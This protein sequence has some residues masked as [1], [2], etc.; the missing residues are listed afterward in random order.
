MNFSHQMLRVVNLIMGA[1]VVQKV[2]LPFTTSGSKIRKGQARSSNARRTITQ[3][4]SVQQACI[5]V[6]PPSSV[7]VWTFHVVVMTFLIVAVVFA[8]VALVAKIIWNNVNGPWKNA[9][10]GPSLIVEL[11]SL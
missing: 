9:P 4:V 3:S 5:F 8:L 7:S 2:C 11:H 10:P 6:Y 1:Y